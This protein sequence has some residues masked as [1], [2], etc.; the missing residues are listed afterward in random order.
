LT[1]SGPPY[2]YKTN[3][4]FVKYRFL[5]KMLILCSLEKTTQF[6]SFKYSLFYRNKKVYKN[7]VFLLYLN[8]HIENPNSMKK[9]N[10]WKA[11]NYD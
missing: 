9:K 5:K 11:K 10:K 3:K 8:E 7:L 1:L 6:F 4:M 2:G